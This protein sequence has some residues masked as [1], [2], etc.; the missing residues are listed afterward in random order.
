MRLENSQ[1]YTAESRP[2]GILFTRIDSNALARVFRILVGAGKRLAMQDIA[3]EL[4]IVILKS[5]C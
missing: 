3:S 1:A 5:L 4:Y 2:L